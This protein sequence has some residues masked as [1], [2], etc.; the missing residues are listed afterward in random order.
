MLTTAPAIDV[1]SHLRLVVARTARRL[2]QEAGQELSPSLTSALAAI[3]RHGPL[4]PSELA[5]H[6]RVQRPTATRLLGR[7]AEL[8]LVERAP[9]P[10][11]R[12]SALISVSPAG[13]TLLRRLRTRKNQYLARRLATLTPDEVATLD[14][15]AAI[16]ERMLDAE[17]RR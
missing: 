3:D 11:D 6:E 4:T 17:E 1:A 16:L 12:R 10:V 15:A 9:D 2:R 13:R 7:L 8:G 14:R 5:A